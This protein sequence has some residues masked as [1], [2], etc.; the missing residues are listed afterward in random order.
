MDRITI[1]CDGVE[2]VI[3]LPDAT[4]VKV[5]VDLGGN[6]SALMH[7]TRGKARAG[8]E[9]RAWLAWDF[10]GSFEVPSPQIGRT[11]LDTEGKRRTVAD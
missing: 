7:L 11:Y 6:A 3:T 2:Q 10:D 4:E 9:A 8:Q 5:Q 1:V